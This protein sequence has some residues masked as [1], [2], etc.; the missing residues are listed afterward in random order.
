M[1]GL[2]DFLDLLD[3]GNSADG[4]HIGD[5][6]LAAET[7][8]TPVFEGRCEGSAATLSVTA[9]ELVSISA[10]GGDSS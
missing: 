10:G 7:S 3:F 6:V 4:L 8:D 5:L 9:S 2:K 1:V